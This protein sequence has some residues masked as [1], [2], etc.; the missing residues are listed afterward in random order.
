MVPVRM[1][2]AIC[3]QDRR[4][5]GDQASARD[6]AE[7]TTPPS[8]GVFDQQ[9][10]EH[11]A[12]EVG[13]ERDRRVGGDRPPAGEIVDVVPRQAGDRERS[14]EQGL[15]AGAPAE[16]QCGQPDQ[17]KQ[18]V[19]DHL[20]RQRPRGGIQLQQRVGRVVLR[21]EEE[22]G[23]LPCVHQPAPRHVAGEGEEYQRPG[24]REVVRGRDAG[25]A[26]H[27]IAADGDRPAAAQRRSRERAVQQLAR[28][29]EEHHERH[30]A[31]EQQRLL[32][33]VAAQLDRVRQLVDPHVI[34][35][36]T[37]AA[38]PR[39]PSS[40]AYRRCVALVIRLRR[41]AAGGGRA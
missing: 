9:R 28:Q 2:E 34:A 29:H 13:Q 3:H 35:K 10:D 27:E 32:P 21:E 26:A 16:P 25:R 40:A 33:R 20:D 19:E 12:G 36:T 8:L 7:R 24:Q 22:D 1:P 4:R 41:W 30:P 15:A 6:G 37:S 39:R 18:Q 5:G 23:N 14:K 17:G 38:I 11:P 31:L